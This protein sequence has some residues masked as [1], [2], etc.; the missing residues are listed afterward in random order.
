MRF[1]ISGHQ[2]DI[3]PALRDYAQDKLGK[4][5]RHFEQM[6]RGTMGEMGIIRGEVGRKRGHKPIRWVMK[7]AGSMTN[8]PCAKLIVCDVCHRSEKPIATSA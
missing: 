1:D 8:S 3:T 5:S 4:L 7:N 6:P 2:M